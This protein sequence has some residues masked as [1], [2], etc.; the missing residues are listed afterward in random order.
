MFFELTLWPLDYRIQHYMNRNTTPYFIRLSTSSILTWKVKTN[1][2]KIFLTFDDG[3]TPGV[4]EKILDL[5]SDYDVK[6]TFFCVGEKVE[7]NREI[8]SKI[9]NGG[10]ATGNHT[11]LHLNGWKTN[12]KEYITDIEKANNLIKSGLF[13]PPYGRI[14]PSQA[15]ILKKQFKIIMWSVL[16]GDFDE[17]ID[18]E[19]CLDIVRSHTRKGSIVVF[20]DSEK[21][22]EKCLYALPR[23][24]EHFLEEGFKFDLLS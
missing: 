4:T 8:F 7:K 11:Y 2:D 6:A 22:V 14:T 19:K 16:S 3:P 5:L 10:H 1:E 20:H 24:L 17:N 12:S 9:I 18:K 21:S 15:F 23:V 13:R